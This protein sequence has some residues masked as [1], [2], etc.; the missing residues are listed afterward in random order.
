MVETTNRH[1]RLINAR[2][3]ITD[4]LWGSPKVY[5]HAFLCSTHLPYRKVPN[6]QRTWTRSSGTVSLQLTA[7][8]LPNGSGGFV[9]QGLPYGAKSRL[10]LLYLCSMAV[11]TKSRKIDIQ[12]S[13]TAFA[14]E[15][16]ISINTQALK[17]LKEQ[18]ARMSCVSMRLAKRHEYCVETFQAPIFSKLVADYPRSHRQRILFPNFV[19]FSHEFYISL[20]DHA[21]PLRKEAVQAL[22]HSAR[23]LD[24]YV[25]LSARLWRL[26]RPTTIRWSSLCFQFGKPDQQFKGFKR[27]FKTALKQALYVYPEADVRVIE[28]GIVIKPSKPPVPFRKD[29]GLL[30]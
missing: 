9:E 16:G 28:G 2:T 3:E 12:D 8:A 24:I 29:R 1:L 26:N 23:A 20:L 21:V 18:V 4:N 7:G 22:S 10:L 13:F 19:E 25:W 6:N 14:R 15:L 11:K 17:A 27:A 30:L 5:N